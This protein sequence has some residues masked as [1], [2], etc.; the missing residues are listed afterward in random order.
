MWICWPE[1]KRSLLILLLLSIFFHCDHP[2]K[3]FRFLPGLALQSKIDPCDPASDVYMD[4]THYIDSDFLNEDGQVNYKLWF[5]KSR[6]ENS[7]CD[8]LKRSK[9][10]H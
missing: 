1:M 3:Y 7:E 5:N 4:G 8:P 9:N 6:P 2:I 10:R